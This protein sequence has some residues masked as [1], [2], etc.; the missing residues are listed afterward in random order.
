MRLLNQQAIRYVAICPLVE[1][2]SAFQN[3]F[4]H[5][6]FGC[7]L[8]LVLSFGQQFFQEQQI[9]VEEKDLDWREND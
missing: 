8:E 7:S 1:I 5:T 3:P 9:V 2:S 4:I 6:A